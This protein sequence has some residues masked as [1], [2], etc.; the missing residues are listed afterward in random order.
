MSEYQYYEFRAID[1]PLTDDEMDE[2]RQ[3]SSRAEITRTS[4]AN[5]YNYGDFRG[6]VRKMM[7]KYFDAFVYL[8]NWGTRRLILRFP[9]NLFD[10]AAAEPYLRDEALELW[11][12]GGFVFLEFSVN[13]EPVGWEEGEGWIDRLLPVRDQL[14]HGDLRSLY[15][16]WLSGTRF[17]DPDEEDEEVEPPLPPGLQK[18]D[19]PLQALAEFLFLDSDLLEAAAQTGTGSAAA[20][21]SRQEWRAWLA[22]L[23]DAEKTDL[24]CRLIEDERSFLAIEL[25]RRFQEQTRPR[26]PD[27]KTNRNRASE[28]RTVHQL[29][30]AR[31]R[32]TEARKEEEAA[33]TAT[34]RK[35]RLADVARRESEIWQEIDQHLKTKSGREHDEAVNLLRDLVEM[36]EQHGRQEQVA[37]RIRQLREQNRTRQALMKRFEQ[38]R[39]PK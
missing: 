22:A 5:E 29:L 21:P 7:E 34:A 9:A 14:L 12:K 13:E 30:E 3:L 1:R 4:F 27:K 19:A 37:A 20:V 16:G 26:S 15:V 28:R 8:A 33:A 25:Q 11:K 35:K 18:L 24:L 32:Y 2:L 39:L 10:M 17:V 23:P 31:D 6:D 36:G 38:A